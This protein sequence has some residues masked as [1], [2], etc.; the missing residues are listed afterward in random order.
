MQQQ[1]PRCI[2]GTNGKALALRAFSLFRGGSRG[3]TSDYLSAEET[4]GAQSDV[5]DGRPGRLFMDHEPRG[6]IIRRYGQL[7]TRTC[8]LFSALVS[9]L[10]TS[11]VCMPSGFS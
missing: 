8:D 5:H 1:S 10:E 11:L 6:R 4:P 7:E 9:C 2:N 3:R